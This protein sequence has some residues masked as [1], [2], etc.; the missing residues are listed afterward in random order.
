MCKFMNDFVY[1]FLRTQT[2]VFCMDMVNL[3][4]IM[5]IN[6]HTYNNIN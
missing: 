5:K 2:I 1:L 3:M 4:F 6:N